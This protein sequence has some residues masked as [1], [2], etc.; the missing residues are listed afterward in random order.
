MLR[1]SQLDPCD[2]HKLLGSAAGFLG[3]IF[4][5]L[6]L[7]VPTNDPKSMLQMDAILLGFLT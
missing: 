5:T 4:A 6:R 2:R 3:P 7:G 1:E